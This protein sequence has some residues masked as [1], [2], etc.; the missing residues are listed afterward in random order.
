MTEAIALLMGSLI[1]NRNWL[2][3]IL[4][5]SSDEAESISEHVHRRVRAGH[6]IFTRW[7]LVMTNFERALYANPDGDLDKL[8]WDLVEHHQQLRRP[9]NRSAPDWA[10]KYHIALFPVYYHNYE[11]G[12]LVTN[13]I[14][15]HL[16][17]DVGNLVNNRAAGEWLHDRVFRPGAKED[18]NSHIKSITGESLSTRYFVESVT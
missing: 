7:C 10:A 9:R 11:L 6:L 8:W 13:Q 2:T 4:G 12:Q 5:I 14:E 1:N 3:D 16:M 18:W 15:H 17:Q